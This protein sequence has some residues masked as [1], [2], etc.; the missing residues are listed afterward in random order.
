MKGYVTKI[1]VTTI[2]YWNSKYVD[3]FNYTNP[4]IILVLKYEFGN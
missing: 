3:I 2:W 4:K 1:N